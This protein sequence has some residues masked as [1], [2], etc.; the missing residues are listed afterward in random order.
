MALAPSKFVIELH[1][2]EIHDLLYNPR[3]PVATRMLEEAGRVV[4]RGARI[5]APVAAYIAPGRPPPGS[6]FDS[7]GFTHGEDAAGLYID[8]HA[9]WYDLFLE[10]PARQMHHAKRTLRTALRDLPRII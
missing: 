5:R 8:I 7:I 4:T 6:L 10:K 2:A 9:M 1:P 3:G